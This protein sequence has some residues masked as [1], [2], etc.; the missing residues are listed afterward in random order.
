MMVRSACDGA[1]TAAGKTFKERVSQMSSA[2][3]YQNAAERRLL[4]KLQELMR[5]DRRDD[6]AV[7]RASDELDVGQQASAQKLALATIECR[8]ALLGQVLARR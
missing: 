4:S 3:A 7:P 8:A 6:I 5:Q 2:N 1:T